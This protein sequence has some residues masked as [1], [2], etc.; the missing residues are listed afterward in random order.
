M[1]RAS[2]RSIAA[3]DVT[4]IAAV[5]PADV[6]ASLGVPRQ[7]AISAAK[8]RTSQTEECRGDQ[9]DMN[10]RTLLDPRHLRK[11]RLYEPEIALAIAARSA[12]S[13]GVTAGGKAHMV[14]SEYA[15]AVAVNRTR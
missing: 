1:K 5:A 14:V 9:Q 15:P 6:F 13:S 8:K 12:G 4:G 2:G 10:T 7:P 3:D 11:D